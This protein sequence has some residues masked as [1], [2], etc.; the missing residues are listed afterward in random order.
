MSTI[1]KT[2]AAVVTVLA[3]VLIVVLLTRHHGSTETTQV[4]T[5]DIVMPDKISTADH[6]AYIASAIP[7]CKTE[8]AKQPNVI[9][10]HVADS[11]ITDY[12][13]CFAD[14]SADA[15]TQGELDALANKTMPPSFMTK[16]Q[17]IAKACVAQY[18]TPAPVPAQ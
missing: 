12:C 2:I 7:S 17:D 3:V 8:A 4:G 11:A 16:V 13:T 9:Q 10:Q 18:L 5:S 15:I 6:D 1:Q 14:K